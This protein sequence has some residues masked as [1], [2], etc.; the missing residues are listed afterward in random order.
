MEAREGVVL[1]NNERIS[2]FLKNGLHFPEFYVTLKM[3]QR[4]NEW[5]RVHS[6]FLGNRK[7]GCFLGKHHTYEQ[8]T[9]EL[10]LPVVEEHHFE[11]V[12]IEFVKE[13]DAWRL[14]IYLDKEGGIT[15]DDLTMVNHE[16]GDLLDREDFIEESYILEVSSPGLLR[17]FK[18]PKDYIRNV[19][20]DVEVKLFA[21]ITWEQ[22][23]KKYTDKE[24]V[25]ILEKYDDGKVWIGFGGDDV[26]ELE[27]KSIA[28]IRKS[29]DF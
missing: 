23:G 13:A 3:L 15:I 26:L 16:L 20:E 12:D 10:L 14:R 19:G 21:P 28:L 6:L 9:E 18:K 8:R 5:T 24:F 1:A 4:I 11:I 2:F 17:P 25:G 29:V 22:D 27:T 7:E